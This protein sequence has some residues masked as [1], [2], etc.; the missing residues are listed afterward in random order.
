VGATPNTDTSPAPS[1][2]GASRSFHRHHVLWRILISHSAEA[3]HLGQGHPLSRWVG[4]GF[5]LRG[6]GYV[7][8]YGWHLT[9]L[10]EISAPS[11]RD[12]LGQGWFRQS[13][14][15]S[16]PVDEYVGRL[17]LWFGSRTSGDWVEAEEPGGWAVTLVKLHRRRLSHMRVGVIFGFHHF[18][19]GDL[20]CPRVT[21]FDREGKGAGKGIY[22]IGR[23]FT[24]A[25]HHFF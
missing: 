9:D 20:A 7:K 3:V 10:K 8:G 24:F 6:R 16:R 19:L 1:P 15:N 4:W 22:I 13:P 5:G 12:C 14:G 21:G 23:G 2:R 25:H 18:F 11:S 17:R